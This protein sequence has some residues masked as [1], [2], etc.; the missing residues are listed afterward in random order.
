[1]AIG[2]EH[3][4][5][6]SDVLVVFESQRGQSEKI[7]HYVAELARRAGFESRALHVSDAFRVDLATFAAAVVIAPVHYGR[8]A[9]KIRR[10]LRHHGETLAKLPVAFVSVSNSAVSGDPCVRREA[11]QLAHRFTNDVALRPTVVVTAGGALAYPRYNPILRWVM[12]R[13]A[14]RVGGPTDT[15][16]IHELTIWSEIDAVLVPF[17]DALPRPTAP[18]TETVPRSRVVDAGPTAPAQY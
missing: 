5:S 13:T 1:M 11:V 18:A 7:A 6:Q 9:P 12:R 16:R 4:A 14:A 2:S 17:F 10:F 3:A 15:S 8:H